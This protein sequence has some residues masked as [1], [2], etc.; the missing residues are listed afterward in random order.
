MKYFVETYTDDLTGIT[1]AVNVRS[2]ARNITLVRTAL[3]AIYKE[4]N[5][6]GLIGP[7]VKV[8]QGVGAL[9]L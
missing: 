7:E 2:D 5:R 9:H 1:C 6:L 8:T 4:L 3:K